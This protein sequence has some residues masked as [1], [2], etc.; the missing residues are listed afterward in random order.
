MWTAM[1]VEESRGRC[2]GAEWLA[3][4]VTMARRIAHPK[5]NEQVGGY[6]AAVLNCCGG[7][8]GLEHG[9]RLLPSAVHGFLLVVL[10]G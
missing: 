8:S 5:I 4:S 6:P 2:C 3:A 7:A 1:Q 9:R 10:C